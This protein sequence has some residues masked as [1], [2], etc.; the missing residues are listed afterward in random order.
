MSITTV[1]F[2]MGNTLLDFHQVKSDHEK[3]IIGL[4][5][6][7][8]C[9]EDVFG[10]SLT[11]EKLTRDFLEPLDHYMVHERKHQTS[12]KPIEA[13]LKAVVPE[14]RLTEDHILTLSRSLYSEYIADVKVIDEAFEMLKTYRLQGMQI[15]V[16]SNCYMPHVL[17]KDVFEAT[18]LA[19]FIDAYFFSY[20][21]GV[22]KPNPA[23]FER[24][25]QAFGV[26]ASECLMIG[27]RLKADIVPAQSLGMHVKHFVR[28]ALKASDDL[29]ID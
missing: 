8:V 19:P 10:I 21:Q 28:Q 24:A 22:K 18:G 23:L 7:R 9:L 29:S 25:M 26:N 5:S 13:F 2:D 12:E 16:I 27:D 14:G 20:E 15:G 11:I 17:Y 6:M 4:E 1:F 3:D